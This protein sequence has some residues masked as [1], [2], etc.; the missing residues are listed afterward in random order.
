[1][2]YVLKNINDAVDGKFLVTK[3]FPKQA[4][5]GTIVHIMDA[6]KLKTGAFQLDYRVTSTGQ[7]YL[8]EFKQ[9]KDFYAWARPDSFIARNY[10]SFSKK[11][12][13]HYVKVTSRTFQ[14]FCVPLICI[15]IVLVWVLA[16]I[17]MKGVAMKI[18]FGLVLSIVAAAAV[19]FIYR[20]QK[21]GVKMK[22]YS[23]IQSKLGVKFK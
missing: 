16:F 13:M 11:D 7:N 20:K 22:M 12:I 4:E 19:I 18:L 14:S 8:I 17:L 1:M 3:S 15:A 9:L 5:A 2:A 10:S 23:M 21:T 6:R